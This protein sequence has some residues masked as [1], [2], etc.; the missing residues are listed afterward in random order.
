MSVPPGA[1]SSAR[2]LSR[3]YLFAQVL[4]VSPES[5]FVQEDALA[6]EQGVERAGISLAVLVLAH[7][8]ACLVIS[9]EPAV[10]WCLILVPGI[11]YH[12]LLSGGAVAGYCLQP[13]LALRTAADVCHHHPVVFRC[14]HAKR[15]GEFL[16]AHVARLLLPVKRF[17]TSLVSW[18]FCGA[19]TITW[20]SVG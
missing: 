2:L 17:S 3:A 5:F 20:K 8:V 13:V 7:E 6:E 10:A 19:T 9:L 4:E 12:K 14:L 11:T 1:F 18:S 15:D 16:P